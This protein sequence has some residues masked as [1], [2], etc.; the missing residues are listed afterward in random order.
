MKCNKVQ[1]IALC[2]STV[3]YTTIGII[4]LTRHYVYAM[5][6]RAL[7]DLN[8]RK[9]L[10]MTAVTTVRATAANPATEAAEPRDL[11]L[12]EL[13]LV[14][15]SVSIASSRHKLPISNEQAMAVTFGPRTSRGSQRNIA[16]SRSSR[17]S[18]SFHGRTAFMSPVCR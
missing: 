17:I 2:L 13:R 3:Q 7:N 5:A 15:L 6:V 8:R 9:F 16:K 14:D 18:T 12:G 4:R 11:R 1:R 10:R